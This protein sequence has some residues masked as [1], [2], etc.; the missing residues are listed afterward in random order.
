MQMS[1]QAFH[2]P[3][4]LVSIEILDGELGNSF[5]SY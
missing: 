1:S 2:Q 3:L 4:N 5:K